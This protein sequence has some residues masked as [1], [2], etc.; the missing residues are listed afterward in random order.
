MNSVTHERRLEGFRA[1]SAGIQLDCRPGPRDWNTLFQWMGLGSS[2]LL[3]VPIF[4]FP[5][6]FWVFCYRPVSPTPRSMWQSMAVNTP[7]L[8]VVTRECFSV[9][10]FS[11]KSWWGVTENGTRLWM[12][13]GNLAFRFKQNS[14]TPDETKTKYYPPLLLDQQ[15]NPVSWGDESDKQILELPF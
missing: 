13:L 11:G 1:V 6:C 12:F 15:K 3:S 14:K 2:L 10:A 9:P 4:S 5:Q 8:H 7:V